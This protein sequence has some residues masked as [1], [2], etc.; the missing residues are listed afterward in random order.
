MIMV[1]RLL[2]DLAHPDPSLF[3]GL[4]PVSRALAGVVRIG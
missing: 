2:A 3:L 4:R 1:T